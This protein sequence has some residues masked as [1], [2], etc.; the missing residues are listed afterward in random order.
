MINYVILT[1]LRVEHQVFG[2]LLYTHVHSDAHCSVK[3]RCCMRAHNGRWVGC[4]PVYATS[5]R[6]ADVYKV[7]LKLEHMLFV[8]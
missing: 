4:T 3:I 1:T 5:S 7:N 8:M 6:D 2:S